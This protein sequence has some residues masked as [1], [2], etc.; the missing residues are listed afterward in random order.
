MA[1]IEYKIL[2][3][4]FMIGAITKPFA[5]NKTA[6]TPTIEEKNERRF[7]SV[8]TKKQTVIVDK[9]NAKKSISNKF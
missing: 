9:P 7:F 1:K 3:T 6:I 5:T 2:N 4:I 8:P